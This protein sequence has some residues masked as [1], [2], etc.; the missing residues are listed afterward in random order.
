M[1]EPGML[2]SPGLRYTFDDADASPANRS[3][4]TT[5]GYADAVMTARCRN[6]DS[7]STYGRR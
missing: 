1:P 2:G 5:H 4:P 7:C 6:S 3:A